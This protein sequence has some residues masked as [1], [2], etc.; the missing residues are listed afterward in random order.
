MKGGSSGWAV[1]LAAAVALVS[2]GR[3]ARAAEASAPAEAP[4][5]AP[6]GPTPP[7]PPAVKEQPRVWEPLT[8]IGTG[9]LLGGGVWK[10]FKRSP[11]WD[12]GL[13]GSWDL[14]VLAGTRRIL[15]VEVAYVGSASDVRG[16]AIDDD[17]FLL[18]NGVEGGLRLNGPVV[19]GSGMIAP[20][21]CAGLGWN[22]YNLVNAGGDITAVGNRDDVLTVPVGGGISLAFRT[23]LVEA[24][25]TY[26][27]VFGDE[28][29]GGAGM[30]TWNVGLAVGGEF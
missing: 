15:A 2:S 25:F 21:A 16:P 24:R 17:V 10:A 9:V 28:L 20:F 3:A 13:G 29:F 12:T 30:Q 5:P 11:E 19:R 4:T 14:R 26:R 18:R 23:L 7:A 22:R 27:P 1:A 8:G 6:F